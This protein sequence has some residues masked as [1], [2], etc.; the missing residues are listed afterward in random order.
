MLHLV[1][2]IFKGALRAI[3]LILNNVRLILVFLSFSVVG[4]GKGLFYG[5]TKFASRRARVH[6]FGA[7]CLFQEGG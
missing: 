6:G 1:T 5:I 7:L 2:V 4:R 3:S